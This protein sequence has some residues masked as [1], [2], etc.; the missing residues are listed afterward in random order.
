MSTVPSSPVAIRA[1]LARLPSRCRR[2]GSRTG[3]APRSSRERLLERRRVSCSSWPSV[4]RIAWLIA[5]GASANSSRG[6][7]AASVPIAV[8]PAASSRA[9]RLLGLVAGLRRRPGRAPASRGYTRWAVSVPAITPNSTPSRMQSIATAVASRRGLELG[10]RGAHRPRGVD[11]DDLGRRGWRR[12]GA[13]ARRPRGAVDRHARA[14]T[15]PPPSGQI[16]VL[17]SLGGEIVMAM[18]SSGGRR[19]MS[20]STTVM[21]SWPPRP[22]AV[23]A[24]ECAAA[25]GAVAGRAAHGAAAS[26]VGGSAA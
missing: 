22:C 23:S 6:E 24:S 1:Q 11:D 18:T 20:G 13:C 9:H 5:A 16:L 21:L 15:S 12:A 2:P 17:V 8:P 19:I 25:D 26:D 10:A 3:S 4:S 14:L 7:R